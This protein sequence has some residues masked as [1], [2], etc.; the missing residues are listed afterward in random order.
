[1]DFIAPD[2]F[3]EKN[4][5]S[6]LITHVIECRKKPVRTTLKNSAKLRFYPFLI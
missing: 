1:M 5:A 6:I 4:I 3:C 2:K